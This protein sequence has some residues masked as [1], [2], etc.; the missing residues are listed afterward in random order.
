MDLK[1]EHL[2][3]FVAV[4]ECGAI[5]DAAEQ[6]GRTASAVSMTLSHLENQVGGKLFE[7]ERKT[8]LTPLGKYCLK[9]AKA[10]VESHRIAVSDIQRF[11]KGE[12]G[13]SRIAVVPSVATR[14]LPQAISQLREQVN[15][16]EVD[17]RDIDSNAIHDVLHSGLVNFG[18]ASVP[19]DAGLDADLLL[20]D[21]YR[22]ICRQDHPL[23]NLQ[24]PVKWGDIDANEFIVNGLC[25]QISVPGMQA[26][27]ET[28]SLYMHNTQSILAFVEG[29]F[30]VTILPALTCPPDSR[31]AALSIANLEMKRALYILRRKSQSLSPID[32]RLIEVIRG[33]VQKLTLD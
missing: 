30:G 17:I 7:G 16:L 3:V 19:D 31:Y 11:A 27:V 24:R 5:T 21:A 28:S 10:A 6:I 22:L 25:E 26:L 2:R 20:E 23:N 9:Q 12:S 13:L 1:L 18:I 15:R 8:R 33:S 32:L 4:A 14:I 29:G